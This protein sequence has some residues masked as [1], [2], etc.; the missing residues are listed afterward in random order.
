MHLEGT[1]RK[2]KKKN[3]NKPK[4][5]L[6]NDTKFKEVFVTINGIYLSCSNS[7]GF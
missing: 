5:K 1:K 6:T 7:R 2:K 4:T 3:R